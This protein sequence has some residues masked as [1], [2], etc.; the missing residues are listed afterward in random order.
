MD[1]FI[2]EEICR[3]K[4]RGVVRI[5]MSSPMSRESGVS[6]IVLTPRVI[7]GETKWQ[8][9]SFKGNQVFHK[10]IETE[11]LGEYLL[12]ESAR[13]RQINMIFAGLDVDFLHN[14]KTVRRK[15]RANDVIAAKV[16]SHNREKEYILREG[17]DIPAL[18]DLGVFT[19]DNRI[20]KA[21]YDKYRQINRFVEIIDDS[22][23]DLS[24]DEITILDFGSG[25]SYLT[26]VVYYYFTVI[27][28]KK[29]NIIGYDL[30]KDVV[31][32]CN[33]IAEKYGYE[34]SLKF[35][36]SDVSRDV[37]YDKKIDIIISLH[38]CDTATDYAL[39]YAVRKGA[40][41]IFSAPCCQHEVNLSIKKGGD[42]DV[43]MRYGIIKER[44][45]A[46]ITDTVR[47]ELLRAK[48][49][50]VDVMEF[51]D[52]AHSPKN[53]MIRASYTGRKD[54]KAIENV[55]ELVSKYGFKQTLFSLL[56]KTSED[57]E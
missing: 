54:K 57:A 50:K 35:V 47:A 12:R 38:A 51:V 14:G 52:L 34:K 43:L 10:N 20:V 13:Y 46:L 7:K 37:L 36:V 24:L 56:S 28:G 4:D 17:E 15:E 3:N 8:A 22:V 55:E 25:K 23:K 31:A 26:F 40:K 18:R 5:I 9:E 39:E 29:V 42:M 33:K 21:K 45:S 41:Y 6:K 19:A 44:L 49:Y 11:E 16:L 27:K 2:Y 48:G 1:N 32:E 30:K 53:L